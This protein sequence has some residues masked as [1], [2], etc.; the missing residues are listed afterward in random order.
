M[1]GVSATTPGHVDDSLQ[2]SLLDSGVTSIQ[3]IKVEWGSI[4][5]SGTTATAA[6]W[7]KRPISGSVRDSLA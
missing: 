5:V 6:K 2:P 7:E 4:S 3:L 1:R